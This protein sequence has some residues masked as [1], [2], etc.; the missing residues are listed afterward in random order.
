MSTKY[1]YSSSQLLEIR[2]SYSTTV[3]K[4]LR[5]KLFL[6]N[7]WKPGSNSKKGSLTSPKKKLSL[8]ITK[9]KIGSLNTRSAV[10]KAALLHDIIED[11]KLDMLCLTETWVPSDA[12][13]AI[14]S[15]LAPP[16][17]SAKHHHRGTY[18]D[19]RGG[20]IAFIHNNLIK[21]HLFNTNNHPDFEHT[22]IK[23]T[24]TKTPLYIIII[25]RPPDHSISNFFD[26]FT[27]LLEEMLAI[28]QNLI[29]CGDF[30]T[31]GTS[32]RHNT[33]IN[34]K[35]QNIIDEFSLIQH[36]TNPTHVSGN[37]LDLV[38]T[39]NSFKVIPDNP[40]QPT[41]FSDHYLI[42]S[43]ISL[44][45]PKPISKIVSYR[46]IK[47]IDWAQF[48]TDLST[49]SILDHHNKSTDQY[50]DHINN[51]IIQLLDK[52]A[53]IRTKTARQSNHFHLKTSNEAKAAKRLRRKKEKTYFDNPTAVNKSAYDLAKKEASTAILQSRVN[54]IKDEISSSNNSRCLWR[55]LNKLL[56]RHEQQHMDN[57]NN[58]ANN[59][60]KHFTDKIDTIHHNITTQLS[61]PQRQHSQYMH[62]HRPNNC[63]LLSTFIPATPS[64][65]R[66]I[67][68]HT[69]NKTSPLD[70]FP[71]L[72]LK[73][74]ATILSIAISQ[75]T[76]L[77]F[78]EGHFPSIYKTAQI[79][80]LIK[81]SN[82]D[83]SN[84]SNF[85]PI[86]NLS[87]ISKIIERVTLS[88]LQP[89]ITSNPNYTAYQSAYRHNYST[90]TALL[91][92]LDNVF[93]SCDSKKVTLLTSL[94]LSAA[95]DTIN[96]STLLDRLKSEFGI[97]DIAHTWLSSYL[98]N[99]KQFIKLGIHSST[100]T[101]LKHGVPQ[102]SVLGPLLF[103]TYI[104]PISH[105][106]NQFNMSYHQYADD[107]Q[108]LQFIT[109]KEPNIAI[110]NLISCITSIET[111]FL[112]NN[113][114]FNS[115]KTEVIKLGTTFQLNTLTDLTSIQLS[116]NT[117]PISNTLKTLG[118]TFDSKLTFAN[119]ITSII[120]S[121]NYHL[122]A[123]K[124]IRPF[125]TDNL[126]ATLSRCLVISKIDYCNSLFYNISDHELSRLQRT[127]NK[128]ARVS[129]NITTPHHY[130]HHS[131]NNNLFKLH[132]LP[133]EF[134]IH[135]KIA[136]TTFKLRQSSTPSY[137]NELIIE[138]Q[139]SRQLR[140]TTA[141]QL[142]QQQTTNNI[143]KRAF[144]HSAPSIWNSLPPDI[145][146]SQQLSTFKSKLKTHFFQLAF[147][148]MTG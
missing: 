79:L 126:A 106:M 60:S 15:D 72:V 146:N 116:N 111:W 115:S 90:E 75:L 58:M 45:I 113:L 143:S 87:T 36:I 34:N 98:S 8:T 26:Q 82:L 64:E 107:T 25:Y 14:K 73:N 41:S 135:F 131:S 112:N 81:K 140:S 2:D 96:H 54:A 47:A 128:A 56:H 50:A 136:T 20:G 127:L 93:H 31:P 102:G 139:I 48:N 105:I 100:I 63:T 148:S 142:V 120:Q 30:N 123:I 62:I 28:T 35:L 32:N 49:S 92:V 130:L 74:C 44:A 6:N 27:K 29:I 55:N 122:R 66:K 125:I 19:G 51:T 141:P 57:D 5:N 24:N 70:S 10:N 40:P 138:K 42:T 3:D 97:T 83:P 118:V 124:H 46:N 1:S 121:S 110:N 94:D 104:S 43:L 119:H 134:R 84:P 145:R 77:S 95:F 129:L 103:T 99:R 91:H 22:T 23:I 71:H 137:L 133:V 7:I 18:E 38:I 76:N 17:F 101:T 21:C 16:G 67:I 53:P 65:I 11:Y 9:L 80:P 147:P 132:W 13:D 108:L 61:L 68:N 59:F 109:P 86:S 88:R 85:R 114:Q 33:C 144:R 39:H 89:H 4:K 52:H 12:P 117:I 78:Q 37:I 69:C